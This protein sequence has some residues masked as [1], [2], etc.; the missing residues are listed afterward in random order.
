MPDTQ[1]S[2]QQTPDPY[3]EFACPGQEELSDCL[4]A[5]EIISSTAR[6]ED[7]YVT[8]QALIPKVGG[9]P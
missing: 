5:R 4:F 2:Q 9:T 3:A 7:D 8:L 6:E 1:P